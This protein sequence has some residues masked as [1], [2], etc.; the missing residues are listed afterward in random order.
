[1]VGW[2]VGWWRMVKVRRI[3]KEREREKKVEDHQYFSISSKSHRSEKWPASSSSRKSVN[4]DNVSLS[5]SNPNI[6]PILTQI[7]TIIKV[8]RNL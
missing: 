7:I 3:L 8:H 6:Y 4:S 1:M 2:L 5:L